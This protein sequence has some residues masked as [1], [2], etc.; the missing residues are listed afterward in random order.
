MTKYNLLLYAIYLLGGVIALFGL[1]YGSV[2]LYRLYCQAAGTGGL[3]KSVAETTYSR[4]DGK[5]ELTISFYGE[6]GENLPW[7][8]KPILQKIKI[9]PGDTALTFY[10]AENKTDEAITGISTYNLTPA[11][12]GIYFNKIQCFCFEEQRLKGNEAIE[13]PILFFIDADIENDPKMDDV[14]HI[15]LSYTFYGVDQR[16]APPAL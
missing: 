6:T 5:R 13:M 1:C 8:F 10:I 15:T 11:R 4:A 12:A 2:P 14:N 7:D 3:E 16:S 9:K